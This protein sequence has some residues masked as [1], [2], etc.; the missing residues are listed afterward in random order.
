V[1]RVDTNW[2]DRCTKVVNLYGRTAIPGIIDTHNHIVL[3]GIR[4]GHDVRLENANSIQE[5]Q[6]TLA[7]KAAE[8]PPGEW[9]TSLG[10]FS[11]N[12]V[13][14]ANGGTA[15]FPSLAELTAAVPNHPVLIIESFSGPGQTNALGKAYFTDPTRAPDQVTIGVSPQDAGFIALVPTSRRRCSR[16]GKSR[17]W[18]TRSAVPRM[19]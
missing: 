15:R 19:P 7:A 4:P 14:L 6:D 8:I 1:G 16:C 5:M 2:N 10:G 9:V 12:Q 3:L 18:R 17:P 11:R 13:A